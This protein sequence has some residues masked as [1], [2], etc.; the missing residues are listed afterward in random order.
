MS[1]TTEYRA[2]VS[3]LFVRIRRSLKVN[4]QLN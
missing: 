4:V 1:L 2:T 3:F